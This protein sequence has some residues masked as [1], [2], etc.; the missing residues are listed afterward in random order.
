[1]AKERIEDDVTRSV[2]FA[3]STWVSE[4]QEAVRSIGDWRDVD[5]IP[6][7]IWAKPAYGP[8][9][10]DKLF[11]ASAVIIGRLIEFHPNLHTNPILDIYAAINAWHADHNASRVPPQPALLKTLEEAVRIVAGVSEAITSQHQP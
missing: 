5:T 4:A 10:L 1:M 2:L 7:E 6:A 9:L 11:R 3:V 8:S